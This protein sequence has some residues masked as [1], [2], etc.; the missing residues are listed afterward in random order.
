MPTT[1]NTAA[2]ELES[3]NVQ[4][5]VPVQGAAVSIDSEPGGNLV[6][7]FDPSTATATRPDGSNDLVFE[8]DGGGRVTIGGFFEVGDNTL[9]DLTLPDGTVVAATD[10]F[11]GSDL[12]MA[13]AAGPAAGAP[14][15]GG[16]NYADDGGA[17]LAGL[18]K[19]GS[20]GTD[21]WGRGTE[22]GAEFQ[23][24]LAEADPLLPGGPGGDDTVPGGEDPKPELHAYDNIKQIEV[25]VTEGED[26][27]EQITVPKP[28]EG[29]TGP[30]TEELS[31]G[32]EKTG[33]YHQESIS[34]YE[35]NPD[36]DKAVGLTS[37]G[38]NIEEGKF[39]D[40]WPADLD[41]AAYI[42]E[43]VFT[44]KDENGGTKWS[45]GNS[46]S[47][48][49]VTSVPIGA[50][51]GSISFDWEL[52]ST[53]NGGQTEHDACAFFLLKEVDGE[54]VLHSFDSYQYDH[55]AGE[56]ATYGKGSVTWDDLE[57]GNYKVIMT[58]LEEGGKNGQNPVLLINGFK[59]DENTVENVLVKE[60]DDTFS[61][62]AS[63]NVVEDQLF[64]GEEP[65]GPSDH[66]SGEGD[67]TVTGFWV[68][69]D[70]Y[71]AGEEA[72]GKLN[73]FEYTFTMDSL[74][75]YTL[76]VPGGKG[77]G[78][79]VPLHD[80]DIRYQISA[81]EGDN[82]LTAEAKLYLL[83]DDE[84]IHRGT[85]SAETI[86]GGVGND[87]IYGG[88]GDDLIYGGGGSDVMYSG[89]GSN[90]FAWGEGDLDGS[91]DVINGF[92]LGQDVLRFDDL[93]GDT[94]QE[95]MTSLLEGAS[96][97]L[98]ASVD[99]KLLLTLGEGYKYQQI[100]INLSEG[101]DKSI[102]DA[103]NDGDS[104]TQAAILEQ[105]LTNS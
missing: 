68:G 93:L 44:F 83:T 18:D 89:G 40:N 94:P 97:T 33:K 78:F 54:W 82:A 100:E 19:Y 27:Y 85:D 51:G 46:G 104:A 69:E 31:T 42:N 91:K 17:L 5:P 55:K 29:V 23:S 10:F 72:H 15:S 45:G 64:T 88:D 73:G 90:T 80:L 76:D 52:V 96:L 74:G 9:P 49:I 30:G 2:T 57:P 87:V 105:L 48:G 84:V 3:R 41:L 67:I 13:T 14:M 60:G 81:G 36:Q 58:V 95:Q 43:N 12:D 75:N 98:D 37:K 32:W 47:G 8:L 86:Y 38:G 39:A 34:G 35:P 1:E 77:D 71:Q 50:E 21:Y 66:Y 99:N 92:K 22:F 65:E 24:L 101:L 11:A 53:Q 6:F 26:V 63:G 25:T 102:A 70:Y 61:M 16:T 56:K 103:L 62:H 7:G 59:A 28:I 79:P 20:L 4:V